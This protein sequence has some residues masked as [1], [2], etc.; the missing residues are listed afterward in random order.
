M[1][2]KLS[3][4]VSRVCALGVLVFTAACGDHTA[5]LPPTVEI[6]RPIDG[7]VFSIGR[8]I[9]LDCDV[10]AVDEA[11]ELVIDWSAFPNG[12]GPA[13]FLSDSASA[14]TRDLGVGEHQIV[15]TASEGDYQNNDLVTITVTNDAPV[16]T[17][18]NPDPD[19]ELTFFAGEAIAYVGSVF[20]ADLNADLED[21]Q[22]ELISTSGGPALRT[23]EGERGTIA[24]ATLEPGEY[25]LTAYVRDA[26]GEVGTTWI[27]FQVLPDPED[28]PPSIETGSVVATPIDGND[29]P[30][31]SYFVEQCLVDI[32]GDGYHDGDDLCQ[33]LTFN[34][35]VTDDHD[36]PEEL[37]YTWT[38]REDDVVIDTF[39]TPASVT[40]LDF[41]PGQYELELVATDTAG[42]DSAPYT[43][44]F[45]VTTL[46]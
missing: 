46:I 5:G 28:L 15:C 32:T 22:W 31:V 11:A 40:Q 44:P 7:E 37:T 24:A 19:G 16:V 35:V 29:N 41:E 36:A 6:L 27:T 21:L 20:D 12:A 17:I 45:I 14:S 33:R 25:Q 38:V 18:V 9:P 13:I 43:F 39:T 4:F 30:P 42:N 1:N 23:D 3:F 26:L 34:A 2:S 10:Q 8:D